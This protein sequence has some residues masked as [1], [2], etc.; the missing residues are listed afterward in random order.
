MILVEIVGGAA[1]LVAVG[2]HLDGD[3][4]YACDVALPLDLAARVID[5]LNAPY[6]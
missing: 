6:V 1:L 5:L 2:I 3:L 4:T